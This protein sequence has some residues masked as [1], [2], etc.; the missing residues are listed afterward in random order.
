MSTEGYIGS[1]MY[2]AI[3]STLDGYLSGVPLFYLVA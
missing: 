1:Y 2:K 3:R